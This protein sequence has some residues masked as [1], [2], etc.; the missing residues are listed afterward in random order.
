MQLHGF[1]NIRLNITSIFIEFF[2]GKWYNL[3]PSLKWQMLPNREVYF[4][5]FRLST[6]FYR[7]LVRRLHPCLGRLLDRDWGSYPPLALRVDLCPRR[8]HPCA[9]VPL[10]GSDLVVPCYLL[11]LV[12]YHTKAI[13][14]ILPVAVLSSTSKTALL[15]CVFCAPAG[16]SFSCA[17]SRTSALIRRGVLLI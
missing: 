1:A 15:R 13:Y 2:A 5:R 17:R 4:Q 11:N 3:G 7:H 9:G 14:Y 8:Y 16:S 6:C 10:V 12:L